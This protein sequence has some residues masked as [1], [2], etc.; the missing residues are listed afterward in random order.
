MV[1]YAGIDVSLELSSVW[2]VDAKGT[3]VKEA[4]VASE[5]EALVSFFQGLGFPVTRIGLEAG[6]C[7]SGCMPG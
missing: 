6:R 7:R 5:P 1:Q 3:S 2:V 4:Q